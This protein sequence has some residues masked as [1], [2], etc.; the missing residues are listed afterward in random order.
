M[1]EETFK[2]IATLTSFTLFGGAI[3]LVTGEKI[4]ESKYAEPE[5]VYEIDADKDGLMDAVVKCGDKYFVLYKGKDNI[6]TKKTEGT[7]KDGL[8]LDYDNIEK[9]AIKYAK[10]IDQPKT[11]EDI[12]KTIVDKLMEEKK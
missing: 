6:C 1:N 11:Q 10:G 5:K 4:T 2:V 9:I 12:K 8:P 7:T 3:G